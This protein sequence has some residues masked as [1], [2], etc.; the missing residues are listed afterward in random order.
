VEGLPGQSAVYAVIEQHQQYGN[1]TE[2]I[3]A[4]NVASILKGGF[5]NVVHAFFD[6][7]HYFQLS[8]SLR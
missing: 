1:A 5:D 6:A 3:E 7:L 8:R 2:Q 4:G